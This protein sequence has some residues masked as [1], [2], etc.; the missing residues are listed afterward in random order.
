MTQSPEQLELDARRLE[1]R[2][3]EV[4]AFWKEHGPE[5]RAIMDSAR[6]EIRTVLTPE[7]HQLDHGV[8]Q[9]LAE[10]GEH[11]CP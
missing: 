9:P 6:A 8:G 3:D 10:I 11:E 4:D 5:M 2:R 1:R 7:Q